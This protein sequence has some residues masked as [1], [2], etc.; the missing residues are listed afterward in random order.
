[1]QDQG[2]AWPGLLVIAH[3]PDQKVGMCMSAWQQDS[4]CSWWAVLVALSSLFAVVCS[5]QC[6]CAGTPAFLTSS[7]IVLVYYQ[8]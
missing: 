4:T 2:Q 7:F 6:T 5:L 1:M 3:G 8:A